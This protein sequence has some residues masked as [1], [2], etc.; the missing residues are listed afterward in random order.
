[1]DEASCHCLDSECN[2]KIDAHSWW[3][4]YCRLHAS[5]NYL[6]TDR[7]LITKESVDSKVTAVSVLE[8]TLFSARAK[9]KVE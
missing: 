1:M 6:P 4:S 2:T 5:C 7:L 3:K 9:S 8:S